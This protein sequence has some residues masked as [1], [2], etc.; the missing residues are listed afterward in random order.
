MP[1]R[2]A[3]ACD[4]N[5]KSI[6]LFLL[7]ALRCTKS[8]GNVHAL[9]APIA[10]G[11]CL[12][13]MAISFNPRQVAAAENSAQLSNTVRILSAQQVARTRPSVE[14]Q[15]AVAP[16]TPNGR[17]SDGSISPGMPSTWRIGS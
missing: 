11:I 16:H 2:N 5:R 9:A 1:I 4:T 15:P 10:K 13:L 7:A 12:G 3:Q 6:R 14:T 8:S 17:T